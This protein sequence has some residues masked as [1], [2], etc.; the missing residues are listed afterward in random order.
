MS[1]LPKAV[2]YRRFGP[3]SA[4]IRPAVPQAE[5]DKVYNIKYYSELFC[6]WKARTV[7]ANCAFEWRRRGRSPTPADVARAPTLPAPARDSRRDVYPGGPRKLER[8]AFEVRG[9]EEGA[10]A[11][12][13]PPTP[14]QP[15]KWSK[16]RPYLDN[17][18]QARGRRKGRE[19][20]G[21]DSSQTRCTMSGVHAAGGGMEDICIV[22]AEPLLYAAYGPCGHKDTCS[23]CVARLRSVLKDAR[24]VYCQQSSDAVFVTRFAGDY[25]ESLGAEEFGRLQARAKAG[26]LR[27]LGSAQA[28]FDDLAHY[29][30]MAALCSYTHPVVWEE[31]GEEEAAGAAVFVAEQQVYTKAQLDRHMKT[32]DLEGPMAVAGFK[33]H[34]DCR[35]AHEGAGRGSACRDKGGGGGFCRRRFYGE[36]ELYQHMHAAHEQCFLCR[37]ARPDR[38]VY[39][40]DYPDLESECFLPSYHFRQEHHPCPHPDCLERK[41]VVF[42]TEQ[43]ES[44]GTGTDCMGQLGRL[45]Q[46]LRQHTAREH[47][48]T[49]SKAEK[50]QALTLPVAFT[51]RRGPEQDAGTA[52]SAHPLAAAAAGQRGAVVIGG[53]AS[54]PGRFA[55]RGRGGRGGGLAAQTEQAR[56]GALELHTAA[57]GLLLWKGRRMGQRQECSGAR[58][59]IPS[60]AVAASLDT[61]AVEHAVRESAVAA[62]PQQQQQGQGQAAAGGGEPVLREADFPAVGSS[63]SLAGAAGGRWAGGAGAAA[64]GGALR[65]EDFPA[66]PGTSKSAKRRAAAK[67]KSMAQALGAG[68]GSRVRVLNAVGAGA[69]PA[70]AAGAFPALPQGA[71]AQRGAAGGSGGAS[72]DGAGSASEAGSRP[73]SAGA[74]G[75]PVEG[76]HQLQRDDFEAVLPRGR[77]SGSRQQQQ[78]QQQQEREGEAEARPAAPPLRTGGLPRPPSAQEIRGPQPEPLSPAAAAALSAGFPLSPRAAAAEAAAAP[79]P[80]RGGRRSAVAPGGGAAELPP[81]PPAAAGA[82]AGAGAAGGAAGPN[83]GGGISE[84]LREA[85]R[86]LVGRIKARLSPH[87]FGL[88]R[89]QSAA[90]VRGEASSEE[91][92]DAIAALGL[93]SLVPDLAA[94]CPDTEKCA[95]L[96]DS[97][98]RA[99]AGDGRGKGKAWMPPE[100]AAA[101]AAQ[102]EQYS[103]WQCGQC[104]LINAPAAATC[105]AC[106]QPKPPPPTA[107]TAGPPWQDDLPP[108]PV[109]PAA[110]AGAAGKKKK[111]VVKQKLDGG[112]RIPPQLAAGAAPAAAA[113]AS[114]SGAAGAGTSSGSSVTTAAPADAFPALPAAAPAPRAPP[115][116]AAPAALPLAGGGG[117]KGKAKKQSLQDF[118]TQAT[119]P[120]AGSAWAKAPGALAQEE[121]AMLDAWG[122]K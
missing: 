42:F 70:P 1:H 7:A 54:V 68:A 20:G 106:G 69:A 121:R 115:P 16:F 90:W 72:A 111:P 19:G 101:A 120:R 71:P 17:D 95:E 87:D 10:E 34:P 107:A 29:R 51:Y 86:Q 80:G 36:N 50:R 48:E 83:A 64:A 22:C 25:T 109:A 102:A 52:A 43:V 99:F 3:A 92:H 108:L 97:H 37:R 27:Y 116:A 30:D 78:Q 6:W 113:A 60:Q 4:P 73:G 46:E 122:N 33:G 9:K 85:N 18:N 88:F 49:L 100:A 26:E 84:A 47:G 55:Q 28:Y 13:V 2:D 76:L 63:S 5:E 40:R 96:L 82:G 38:F 112:W 23:K 45:A 61:A 32:G 104:T 12:E 67:K 98:R 117:K 24:C 75:P 8:Y 81:R 59:P 39:Y 35:R 65:A 79:G 94:T 105:E 14:A 31:R 21:K 114:T 110:A 11:A 119:A 66:L 93:V 91:Y 62:A 118:Y 89:H 57:L 15:H 103:S 56:R 53:A 58:P 44:A 41:F 74:A 77:L